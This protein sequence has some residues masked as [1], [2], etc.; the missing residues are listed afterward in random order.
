[1]DA[2]VAH[3]GSTMAWRGSY[4]VPP[5]LPPAKRVS[6][7]PKELVLRQKSW[8]SAKK[9]PGQ[10]WLQSSSKGFAMYL[11]CCPSP[12]PRRLLGPGA[13]LGLLCWRGTSSFGAGKSLWPTGDAFWPKW[14]CILAQRGCIL[15]HRGC[16]LFPQRPQLVPRVPTRGSS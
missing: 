11:P 15:A 6:S 1:M 2:F 3:V 5:E 9:P 8:F 10:G 7:P 14:G 16:I 12:A 13:W 4:V